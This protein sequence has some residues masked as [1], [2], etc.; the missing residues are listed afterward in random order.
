MWVNLLSRSAWATLICV[1]SPCKARFFS[2]KSTSNDFF[3]VGLFVSSVERLPAGNSIDFKMLQA[4]N[5][6]WCLLNFLQSIRIW[7]TSIHVWFRHSPPDY[8]VCLPIV[9][10]VSPCCS[11]HSRDPIS[12]ERRSNVALSV[13]LIL[14]HLSYRCLFHFD[15]R[16][17]QFLCIDHQCADFAFFR[18]QFQFELFPKFAFALF[19][20]DQVIGLMH[21]QGRW[22]RTLQL[23]QLLTKF[24]HLTFGIR[25]SLDEEEMLKKGR[26]GRWEITSFA[27][28]KS[29]L[30]IS[31][32]DER[33]LVTSS[34]FVLKSNISW[35]AL[36][37]ADC[38]WVWRISIS[39]YFVTRSNCWLFN[40]RSFSPR[41]NIYLDDC[42][43]SQ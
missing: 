5:S 7:L 39:A 31:T 6:H 40:C 29:W 20:I 18:G 9:Q 13:S 3:G 15:Q 27:R 43:I 32:S 8:E 41:W 14:S 38:S 34:C 24:V 36:S 33:A 28:S 17:L 42:L 11:R 16:R 23:F 25:C 26:I 37:N 30:R 10:S 35:R 2:N 19:L 4:K 21:C 12:E 22:R 1:C